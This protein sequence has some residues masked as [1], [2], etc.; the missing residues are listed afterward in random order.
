M[1][2]GR[3]NPQAVDPR[4]FPMR[5]ATC[6]A[7][8]RPSAETKEIQ[9]SYVDVNSDAEKTLLMIHGWPSL[10]HSWKYQIE[11]FKNDYH[12]LLPNLRGFG[13]S[14]HPGDVESSSTMEDLVKDLVCILEHAG[15]P[16]AACMGHDWGTQICHEA[17]RMQPDIFDA[18][19]GTGVPYLPYKGTFVPARSLTYM[20]PKLTYVLFFEGKTNEAIK[21]LGNDVR[22]TLRA[23]FRSV[24]SPPPD[25][26]LRQ[27]DS[28]LRGWDDVSDIPPIPFFT[29][30]E[31]DYWVEQ[32]EK[33]RFAHTM[34]FYTYGNRYTSWAIANGQLNQVISAP[35]LSIL[36]TQDPVADWV[37]AT[38]LVDIATCVPN[39]TTKTVAAAHWLQLEKPEEVNA[40]MRKWLNEWY[41]PP[42][43]AVEEPA[44][45]EESTEGG[46]HSKGEE[47]SKE[48][49]KDDIMRQWVG[50]FYPP[51]AAVMDQQRAKD[52]L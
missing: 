3:D 33:D 52:E 45:E 35:V 42:G 17:A 25:A 30:E 37:A 41:P 27:K 46:E 32:Y 43:K 12:L 2:A 7:L 15:V 19:V 47:R 6:S 8:H 38:K 13:E 10:W 9:L 49:E 29:A 22:R 21:E 14:T 24:D 1:V 40:I 18:V 23:T 16:K 51:A 28:F 26:F 48:E 36:P 44:G 39:L 4:A 20:F 5:V 50:Q 31:E 34:Y 11:E